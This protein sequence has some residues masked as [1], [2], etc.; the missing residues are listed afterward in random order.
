MNLEKRI[1][2]LED[3]ISKTHIDPNLD[4]ELTEWFKSNPEYNP[5]AQSENNNGV[6]MPEHLN[7]AFMCRIDKLS[8]ERNLESTFC[9]LSEIDKKFF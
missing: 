7:R 3:N 6:V 9:N 1:S 5:F 8:C 2:K 4:R